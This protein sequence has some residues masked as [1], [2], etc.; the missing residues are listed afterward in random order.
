MYE[1]F[2]GLH[3]P[4][5]SLNPDP[6][7]LWLSETHQEGLSAV[8]YG[9]SRRKGFLMLTGEVGSGKTTLLRAALD[10]LPAD[11]LDVPEVALVSN[12]AELGPLDLLKLACA[13]FGIGGPH[14]PL[15]QVLQSKADYLIALHAFLMDR[16]RAGLT[17]VLVIDEAQNL[18]LTA[19]EQVRL[20]SNLEVGSGKLLQ[21]VLTG[22]PEL[23]RKLADPR[24]R[25][26]RQRIAVEHHVEALSPADVLPYLRH[27]VEVA[28]GRYERIFAIG[29]EPAFIEFSSGCPRLI[30]LLADKCLLAA[31][32]KDM[33]PVVPALVELKAKELSAWRFRPPAEL[34]PRRA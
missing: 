3:E 19:L 34:R 24:L 5:F 4:A 21:I 14:L 27:R 16:Y 10:R 22:Q 11:L 26:L 6:R 8:C 25:Q 20:L 13:E 15:H 30:N 18:S 1:S 7:F 33:R 12:T 32:A 17:C 2:F 29:A 31:Y 28:G 9:I 23:R